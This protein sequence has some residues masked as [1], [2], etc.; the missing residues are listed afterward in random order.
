MSKCVCI[1]HLDWACD[2]F[3]IINYLSNF[4]MRTNAVYSC[5]PPS[6]L[7]LIYDLLLASAELIPGLVANHSM[8]VLWLI[9]NCNAGIS[10]NVHI[11][12]RDAEQEYR[13]SLHREDWAQDHDQFACPR[14][15]KS[16]D[17]WCRKR[18]RCKC[19]WHCNIPNERHY[20][21]EACVLCGDSFLKRTRLYIKEQV[22]SNAQ[23][24]PAKAPLCD[25]ECFVSCLVHDVHYLLTPWR[26]MEIGI[27]S[28]SWRMPWWLLQSCVHV[29]LLHST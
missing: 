23:F 25:K 18:C 26:S 14:S 16:Y 6:V 5:L 27:K 11:Q 13:W 4:W 8:S 12:A 15:S 20:A 2:L 21:T 28:G 29:I 24:V 22:A 9:F 7:I 3:V 17:Q 1:A 19:S 10:Q